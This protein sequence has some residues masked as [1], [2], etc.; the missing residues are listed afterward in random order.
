MRTFKMKDLG[1]L[2]YFLGME[3][4]ISNVHIC[5]HQHKY[6]EGFIKYTQL[7][8]AKDFYTPLELHVKISKDDGCPP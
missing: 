2:T 6:V 5:M 8:G 4:S 7:N 3:I 1:Y